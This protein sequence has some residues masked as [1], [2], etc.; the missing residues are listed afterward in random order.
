MNFESNNEPKAIGIENTVNDYSKNKNCFQVEDRRKII[1][2]QTEI[3]RFVTAV[4]PSEKKQNRNESF[5][6][7]SRNR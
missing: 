4:D 3:Q 6:V 5:H 2:R 7:N 1:R